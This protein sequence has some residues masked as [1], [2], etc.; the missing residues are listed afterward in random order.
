M[1]RSLKIILLTALAWLLAYAYAPQLIGTR[2]VRFVQLPYVQLGVL[3]YGLAYAFWLR[4]TTQ[5]WQTLDH[6]LSHALWSVLSFKPIR[7]LNV[8]HHGNGYVKYQGEHNLIICLAPYFFRLPVWIVVFLV[9]LIQ[10]KTALHLAHL[11]LGASVMYALLAI[12][13]EAR[14]HQPDLNVY[15]LVCSYSW[16][17]AM[18]IVCWGTIAALTTGGTSAT[19]LFFKKGAKHLIGTFF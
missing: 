12:Y 7:E 14:P 11:L 15:G 4:K 19:S 6:E 10:Q 3:A 18:N 16:I 13:D 2:I 5:F 17:I 9:C 1:T 8:H